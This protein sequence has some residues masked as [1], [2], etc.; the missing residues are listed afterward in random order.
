MK[1]WAIN[2]CVLILSATVIFAYQAHGG[3]AIFLK[4]GKVIQV[5]VNKEDILGISFEESAASSAHMAA[6]STMP[7]TSGLLMWLDAA[8]IASLF[9]TADGA[10]PLSSSN[11]PVGLWRDKTGNDNNFLQTRVDARPN[12]VKTGIG[13][14]A[15]ITFEPGQSMIVR[16]NFPAPVTVI[17]VARQLG[18]A[19]NRVLSAVANNWL[20]GFWSGAKNQAYYDGWVSPSGSPPSD[21]L[22]HIFV[23]IVKGRGQ[24]SEV[25]ADGVLVAGNQNGV[26]GPNGLAI[27][28][29]A[30]PG[31]VSN[32]QIAELMVFNRD[33]SPGERQ[34]MEAYLKS[35]WGINR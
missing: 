27:N 4:D 1:K 14:K 7:V 22:P 24:N 2:L 35:K 31:E 16:T 12:F 13:G 8:D 23:G 28:A 21:T 32:C 25:W 34:G 3:M 11:Q 17:Y 9:Q 10:N 29:G 30:Y 20:L 18:G 5:S 19:N 26:A 15:S 6:T 33:L